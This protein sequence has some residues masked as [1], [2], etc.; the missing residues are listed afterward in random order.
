M[1]VIAPATYFKV[2]DNYLINSDGT[3]VTHWRVSVPY[4]HVM[5][6]F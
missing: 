2:P 1:E 3:V 5:I 4:Q 6:H